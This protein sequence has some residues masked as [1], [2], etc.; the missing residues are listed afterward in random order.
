[1]DTTDQKPSIVIVSSSSTKPKSL[2][3]LITG[4]TN[5]SEDAEANSVW[6]PWQIDTKYYTADVNIYGITEQFVRTGEFNNT[7]EALIIHMDSNKESGLDDIQK[8]G[9]IE[10]DC[11][12]EIKLLVSNY[13]TAET[14]ITKTKAT[15]WCLKHGFELIELYPSVK[16]SNSDTE[17]CEII[18]EKMGVDRIIEAV[19]THIWP[20]LIMK[21]KEKTGLET[22]ENIKEKQSIA[23]TSTG[24]VDGSNNDIN[25]SLLNDFLTDEGTDDFTELFSQ[26]HM[27]K[28]S[29]KSMPTSQRKQCAEQMVTAFWRAMGGD[30][31]EISDI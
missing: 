10:N 22:D 4:T 26:L 18:K 8:W 25:I 23:N 13:C 11:D 29:I 21:D 1:M 15:E 19:Q 30:E 27:I 9:E 28:E 3:K 24:K 31:E 5:I 16:K 2:I 14:K 17:D 12:P 20:N 7:V 6:H